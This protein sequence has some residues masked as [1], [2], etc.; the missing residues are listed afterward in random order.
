MRT[1][2]STTQ[3]LAVLGLFLSFSAA[4]PRTSPAATGITL[5]SV[6]PNF[7]KTRLSGG[8]VS[9]SDYAGKVVLLFLLGY[10]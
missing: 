9:L 5:G 6:A 1:Q 4:L 10:N 2:R 3:V 7:T 8:S